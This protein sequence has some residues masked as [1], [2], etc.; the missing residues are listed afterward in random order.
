MLYAFVVKLV[1]ALWQ[2]PLLWASFYTSL[3]FLLYFQKHPELQ[4][5]VEELETGLKVAETSLQK[6]DH[7]LQVLKG[8]NENLKV[9]SSALLRAYTFVLDCNVGFDFLN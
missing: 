3:V 2:Y 4:Q 1:T 7:E 6:S 9:I 8:D 5:K